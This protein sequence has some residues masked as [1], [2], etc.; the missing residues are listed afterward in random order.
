MTEGT[1]W[2]WDKEYSSPPGATYTLR[3]NSRQVRVGVMIRVGIGVGVKCGVGIGLI[4]VKSGVGIWG[5]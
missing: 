2:Y 3:C 5:T 1:T 4:W